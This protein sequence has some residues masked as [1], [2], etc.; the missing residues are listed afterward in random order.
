[1]LHMN[2]SD[3]TLT[4]LGTYIQ[5][6]LDRRGWSQRTLAMYAETTSATISRIMR[7]EVQPRLR[8]L[9]K[10]A[11]A[12]EVDPL[13]LYEEAGIALPEQVERLDERAV[14]IA[15]RL[16]GLPPDIRRLAVTSLNAQLDAIEQTLLF[17]ETTLKSA[18]EALIEEYS[19]E[20]TDFWEWAFRQIKKRD[21]DLYQELL[22]EARR[23]RGGKLSEK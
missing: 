17:G 7:G 3:D 1:M 2:N 13:R 10:I 22:D 14:H 21:P 20:D 15:R 19:S 6:H 23:R 12:L 11:D 9:D 4:S 16:Q 8:T 18:G 5:Q